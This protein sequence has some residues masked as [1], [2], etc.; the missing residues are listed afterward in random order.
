MASALIP[1]FVTILVT[2]VGL[3]TV[4]AS[5][6]AEPTQAS[7]ESDVPNDPIR[8]A[9]WS[10]YNLDFEGA[11][12][13]VDR[14]MRENPADPL[15]YAGRAATLIFAE[16]E[17]L[18]ILELDFFNSDDSLTDKKRLAPDP[19][20]R[21]RIFTCTAEAR[22]LAASRL[23][24]HPND[25]D[26]LFALMMAAGVE[27]QYTTIV[28]KRYLR[29]GSLSKEAQEL[30]DRM[31]TLD[32][33]VY[34]AYVTLGS[35]EYTVAN[36]N[37]FFRFFAKLRGLRGS[38]EK[39]VEHLRIVV[40]N[41]RYYGPYAKILLAVFHVREKHLAEARGLLEELSREFPANPLFKKEIANIDAKLGPSAR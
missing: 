11:L 30:A 41:G 22:R 27:T 3:L 21:A 36:L 4:P 37:P 28:E 35:I 6:A 10:M 16:F 31:L 38:K 2:A 12:D 8:G 7:V 9:I 14:H 18:Q 39:A 1:V 5:H 32:P 29:G 20:T 17:R 23:A 19:G 13:V 25:R 24:A 40:E 26:A 34:D 15:G 33:P